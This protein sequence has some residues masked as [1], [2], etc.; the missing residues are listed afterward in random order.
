MRVAPAWQGVESAGSREAVVNR[1]PG[2]DGRLLGQ[3][4][5]LLTQSQMRVAA[6]WC[7][8]RDQPIELNRTIG[9]REHTADE[10]FVHAAGDRAV[11]IKHVVEWA[12][13]EADGEGVL[14]NVWLEPHLV[15]V[16]VERVDLVDRI[17]V[18]VAW[19]GRF[20]QHLPQQITVPAGI[21]DAPSGDQAH[22]L[23]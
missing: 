23:G 14:I 19:G 11:L 10:P 4:R 20:W 9:L 15:E 8:E 21:L 16:L 6:M 12:R 2:F 17:R 18:Q 3:L 5:L 7:R 1:R 13:H 22:T